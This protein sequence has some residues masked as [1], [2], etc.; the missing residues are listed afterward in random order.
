[1]AR[2]GLFFSKF[3]KLDDKTAVPVAAI[4]MQGIWAAL[5]SLSATFDQLTDGVVF[6]GMI[7]Y[8]SCCAAVFVL[9]KKMPDAPR[10]YRT[11]GYPI[12]PLLFVVVAIWL[13]FNTLKTSPAESRIGL[14]LIALGLPIYF[15]QRRKRASIQDARLQSEKVVVKNEEL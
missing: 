15:W 1:M 8:A 13:L 2:D 4:L 6:A 3:A 10:P 7:F 12:V 14:I 11:F 9:R 5:L